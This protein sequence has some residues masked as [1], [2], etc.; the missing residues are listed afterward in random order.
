MWIMMGLEE[1]IHKKQVIAVLCNQWG[2]SGK[3][4]VVAAIA[5]EVDVIARGTGGNNA[6]HTFYTPEGIE[7]ITHLVPA[8]IIHD[9]E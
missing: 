7:V 4:K 8:G 6:G 9:R 2:D 1:L 5:P 3:G